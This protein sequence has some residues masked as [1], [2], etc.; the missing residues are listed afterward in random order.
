MTCAKITSSVDGET[1]HG[2]LCVW[3][4]RAALVAMMALNHGVDDT[5]RCARR[6]LPDIV[7]RD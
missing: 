2:G 4:N 3:V 5:I 6:M 1:G 7:H